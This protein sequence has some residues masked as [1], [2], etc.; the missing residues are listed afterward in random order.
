[1]NKHMNKT[2]EQN[3]SWSL[4][5]FI[6]QLSIFSIIFFVL[7]QVHR[8][9]ESFLE[10]FD[11]E[12]VVYLTPDSPHGMIWYLLSKIVWSPRLITIPQIGL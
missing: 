4:I 7:F 9:E 12:D 8:T 3:K 11:V 2:N 5:S 1:M 6:M 10:V